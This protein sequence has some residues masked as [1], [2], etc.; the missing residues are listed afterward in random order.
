[1]KLF[2]GNLAYE[3]TSSDLREFFEQAGRVMS[4]RV[5]EDS[6]SGRSKGFGFVQMLDRASAERAIEQFNGV[7]AIGRTLIVTPARSSI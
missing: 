7:D 6:E 1:M 3:I 5:V 4:A 2:V